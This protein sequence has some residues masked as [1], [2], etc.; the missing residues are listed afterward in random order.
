MKE[1]SLFRLYLLRALYLFIGAGFGVY[2]LPGILRHAQPWTLTQG[3]MNC[4]LLAFWLLSLLG[5]RYP[6]QMLPV[7]LWELVWKSAWLLLVALPQWQ[8]GT[9][10]GATAGT[11]IE[12][13]LVLLVVLAVPWR[14]V[15]DHYL[16]RDGDPW[17]RASG[18]RP[19]V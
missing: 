7:L 5:L 19:G 8:D 9:M 17:R 16:R 3:V 14:Y 11:A 1:V 2:V 15:I 13:S 18:A 10:D 4:M 12:C 6:L